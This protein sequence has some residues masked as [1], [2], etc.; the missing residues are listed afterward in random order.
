MFVIALP[1]HDS[2][3]S[4]VYTFQV[5]IIIIR[6]EEK[7]QHQIAYR[8]ES[9]VL[10]PTTTEG[11]GWF[12]EYKWSLC[13][14]IKHDPNTTR[15]A[16]RLTNI[17]RVYESV[18]DWL[19]AC[20]AAPPCRTAVVAYGIHC[21]IQASRLQNTTCKTRGKPVECGVN[22]RCFLVFFLKKKTY[23]RFTGRRNVPSITTKTLLLKYQRSWPRHPRTRTCCDL[24]RP[25]LLLL[26]G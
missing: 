3:S 2:Y 16:I 5:K 10:Y 22:F 25:L 24:R 26:L 15:K 14:T 8:H 23:I 13:L 12:G 1:Q 9:L 18:W 11:R 4:V 21:K 17:R 19:N 20:C 7:I 6:F